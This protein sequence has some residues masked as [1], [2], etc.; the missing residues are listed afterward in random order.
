M[1]PDLQKSAISMQSWHSTISGVL[2]EVM[3]FCIF[4][5]N[6]CKCEVIFMLV[7]K[8][9]HDLKMKNVT[10]L[11][12]DFAVLVTYYK[13]TTLTASCDT[14]THS[15]RTS[16]PLAL[17]D[18]GTTCCH[19]PP[20]SK[21]MKLSSCFCELICDAMYAPFSPST[22]WKSITLYDGRALKLWMN[23]QYM[24]MQCIYTYAY[25]YNAYSTQIYASI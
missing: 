19:T 5:T 4:S 6:F 11:C 9:K 18:G 3:S 20:L 8:L 10:I 1:W 24:C 7:T 22:L 15:Q 16:W 13:I 2:K 17:C 21:V 25:T 23:V 14:H 12:I